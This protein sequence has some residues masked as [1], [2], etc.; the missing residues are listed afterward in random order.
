[1]CD[2]TGTLQLF[3]FNMAPTS[4]AFVTVLFLSLALCQITAAEPS[5]K[6]SLAEKI[7]GA[8]KQ[9]TTLSNDLRVETEKINVFNAAQ[10]GF[11]ID[12]G[13]AGII[14]KVSEATTAIS[15]ATNAHASPLSDDD[16]KLVVATLTTFVQVSV[17]NS[18]HFKFHLGTVQS[19]NSTNVAQRLNYMRLLYG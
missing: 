16:A 19:I 10:Q 7:V 6:D 8:I 11:K 12:N 9:I 1:M 3:E 18:V 15:R 14:T 13:F 4:K 17:N 5:L 2:S